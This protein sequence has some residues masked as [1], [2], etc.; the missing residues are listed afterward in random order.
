MHASVEMDQQALRTLRSAKAGNLDA[1]AE[2]ME[3]LEAQLN[4]TSAKLSRRLTSRLV[5]KERMDKLTAVYQRE[6]ATRKHLHN[7]V[8]DVLG[9]FRVVVRLRESPPLRAGAAVVQ[10]AGD[11]RTLL[12]AEAGEAAFDAQAVAQAGDVASRR[13]RSAAAAVPPPRPVLVDCCIGQQ[14]GQAD[15]F[16]SVL[17]LVQ[18]A[19]DG[20]NVSIFCA[21]GASA[22]LSHVL[23]GT[24]RDPGVIPRTAAHLFE[25]GGD[26]EAHHGADQACTISAYML[27]VQGSIMSDLLIEH[28]RDEASRPSVLAIGDRVHV[29]GRD[30]T[31]RYFG[32]VEFEK[33]KWVGVELDVRDGRHDGMVKGKRYFK[34]KAGHATFCRPDAC[35]PLDAPLVADPQPA[36]RLQL[37]KDEAGLVVVEG[38][39]LMEA[40]SADDL[41]KLYRAGVAAYGR[42]QRA[43][44]SNLVFTIVIETLD[45]GGALSTGKLSF[46]ELAPTDSP[47]KVVHNTMDALGDVF[48]ALASV[49]RAVP[50]GLDEALAQ[51]RTP[52]GAI[53]SPAGRASTAPVVPSVHTPDA[54]HNIGGGMTPVRGR[55]TAADLPLRR[56]KLTLLLSDSLGGSAKTLLLL[57]VDGASAHAAA[58]LDWAVASG[59]HRTST[60]LPSVQPVRQ[61]AKLPSLVSQPSA[62]GTKMPRSPPGPAP[63]RLEPIIKGSGRRSRGSSGDDSR[64]TRSPALSPALSPARSPARSPAQSPASSRRNSR[65]TAGLPAQLTTPSSTTRRSMRPEERAEQ[66][67]IAQE[68]ARRER[69]AELREKEARRAARE[70]EREAERERQQ[71]SKDRERAKRERERAERRAAK[72]RETDERRREIERQE[73]ESRERREERRDGAERRKRRSAKSS[74]TSSR[75]ARPSS[76]MASPATKAASQPGARPTTAGALRTDVNSQPSPAAGRSAHFNDEMLVHENGRTTRM[77]SR[78]GSPDEYDEANF[79]KS[80]LMRSDSLMELLHS[81]E[82]DDELDGDET[83][84]TAGLST[85]DDDLLASS[86]GA[87]LDRR[88]AEIQQRAQQSRLSDSDLT[89]SDDDIDRF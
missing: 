53:G 26:H 71:R 15:V 47:A 8:Q 74:S 49:P 54:F 43:A 24:T 41:V 6:A 84:G 19:F 76:A 33:G 3:D 4:E 79:R 50:H 18:S 59:G 36:R 9:Q 69:E 16:A 75:S 14:S 23:R 70:R 65:D 34:T 40:D 39:T 77:P 55:L 57:A 45:A 11:G 60:P 2:T 22:A 72:E 44:P 35:Q 1:L 21:G 86:G 12:V 31:V 89:I 68:Q 73:R 58:D 20:F 66:A 46:V 5:S 30:G 64:A 61:A 62:S 87:S 27:E 38:V 10:S 25:L 42:Q 67:R 85:D 56:N 29:N 32:P 80:V 81:D 28:A 37:A 7:A 52:L 51:A 13:G 78:P 63:G 17:G 83:E 82:D 88:L 48:H